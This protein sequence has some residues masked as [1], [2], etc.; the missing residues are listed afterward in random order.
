MVHHRPH[1][2]HNTAHPRKDDPVLE[3]L[4]LLLHSTVLL[5]KILEDLALVLLLLHL[6]NTVHLLKEDQTL[7][8]LLH[9]HLNMEL[10]LKVL[11]DRPALELHLHLLHPLNTEL[12][13]RALEGQIS[14]QH[15]HLPHLPNMAHHLKA[16]ED[17]ALELH[18]LL[19]RNTVPHRKE[20]PILELLHLHHRPNMAHHLKILEDRPA[21]EPLLQHLL[22][23]MV[24][25]R[26]HSE[27]LLL[28]HHSTEHLLPDLVVRAWKALQD[29]ALRLRVSMEHLRVVTV[30]EDLL[31]LLQTNTV[32]Q[33][34]VHQVVLEDRRHLLGNTALLL[35]VAVLAAVWNWEG[36]RL[37]VKTMP[38]MA[39]TFTDAN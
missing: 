32:P 29:P 2:L 16:L 20:G 24:L 26:P 31:L 3:L 21:L 19:L 18:L 36:H 5:H 25:Q 4:L 27:D 7:E 17:L 10:H 13:L 38:A 1:L 37:E 33:Q 23:N 9:H 8:L 30:S 28:H 12:Q 15:L 34:L 39:V 6:R 22:L 14:G 35:L 11:E